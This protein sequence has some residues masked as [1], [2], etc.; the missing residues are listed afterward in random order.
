MAK[1]KSER[2][3]AIDCK[4]LKQSN[5]HEGYYKYLVT[6][7]EKDGT[8]N[9]QPA[10]GTDM[11]DAISRLVWSERTEK[12]TSKIE[13]S[14]MYISLFVIITLIIPAVYTSSTNN[15]MYLLWPVGILASVFG[16]GMIAEKYINKGK[17]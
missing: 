16:V 1:L 13:K 3:K 11:Q 4:L 7:R 6:I 15:P 9:K 2:R 17:C 10:Y 8:I 5:T 14:P 12:V